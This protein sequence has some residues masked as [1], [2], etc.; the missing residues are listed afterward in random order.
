MTPTQAKALQFMRDYT[1]E[2]E[3]LFP[4]YT[5]IAAHMGVTSKSNAYR[6]CH[7]LSGLGLIQPV[8]STRYSRTGPRGWEVVPQVTVEEIA[9]AIADALFHKPDWV[10]RSAIIEVLAAKLPNLPRSA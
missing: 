8:P 10:D 1:R 5:E 6:I 4:L 9:E 2:H 7:A 3:G